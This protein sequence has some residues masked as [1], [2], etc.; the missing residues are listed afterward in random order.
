MGRPQP[1]LTRFLMIG[2]LATQ[3]G[4][5]GC[6]HTEER[7]CGNTASRQPSASHQERP[8]KKRNLQT[9][10]SLISSP[11]KSEKYNSEFK[12]PVCGALLW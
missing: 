1:N 12:P 6:M 2:N 8:Q 7:P 5:Q 4:H 3:R 10:Y 11:Q 9:L